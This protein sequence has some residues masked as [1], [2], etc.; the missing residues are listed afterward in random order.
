M[1]KFILIPLLGMLLLAGCVQPPAANPTPTPT[2][3]LTAT[4][5][6]SASAVAKTTAEATASPS[7]TPAPTPVPATVQPTLESIAS[8]AQGAVASSLNLSSFTLQETT[9]AYGGFMQRIFLGGLKD[10]HYDLSIRVMH[11]ATRWS[12]NDMTLVA[13]RTG[14]K[15]TEKAEVYWQ[16]T[17]LLD[18]QVNK[19]RMPCFGWKFFI[20][21]NLEVNIPSGTSLESAPKLLGALIDACPDN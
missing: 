21:A 20:E 8:S 6:A 1:N 7:A 2:V 5:T 12:S 10:E 11:P 4:P 3:T 15:G 16:Q 13:P 14:T 17:N 9:E 19:I 18:K